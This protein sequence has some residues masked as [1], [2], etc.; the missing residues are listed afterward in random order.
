M[1]RNRIVL[2][3][4]LLALVFSSCAVRHDSCGAYN[5]GGGSRGHVQLE[6]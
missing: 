6:K 1:K 2:V 3:V 5:R 4:T